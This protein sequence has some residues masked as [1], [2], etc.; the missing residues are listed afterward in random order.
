MVGQQIK[1]W[2]G[3]GRK[4]SWVNRGNFRICL[5]GLRKPTEPV[6][7]A[8]LHYEQWKQTIGESKQDTRISWSISSSSPYA[9]CTLHTTIF[10]MDFYS[11]RALPS[12]VISYPLWIM[13]TRN[14]SYTKNKSL[15]SCFLRILWNV[16]NAIMYV[17][18]DKINF[19]SAGT[20][21]HSSSH[22]FRDLGADVRITLKF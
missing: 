22:R 4:R 12:I 1:N 7:T 6:K 3:F 21:I 19:S 15:S 13:K 14:W 17:L 10:G 2:Q 20:S 18:T 5:Q 9:L 16:Y 11:V 8:S